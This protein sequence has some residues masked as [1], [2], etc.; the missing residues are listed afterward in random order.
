MTY[1]PLENL[2]GH[3]SSKPPMVVFVVCLFLFAVAMVSLGL[4]IKDND[5]QDYDL[6]EVRK[7]CL[8][9]FHKRSKGQFSQA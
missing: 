6:S 7:S 3:A 1:K 4:Y 5:I 9:L 8:G 2:K